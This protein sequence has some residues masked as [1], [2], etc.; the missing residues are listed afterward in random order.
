MI[1]LKYDHLEFAPELLQSV[2]DKVGTVLYLIGF[3]KEGTPV[4][5]V[6]KG[7]GVMHFRDKA[8]L[9]ETRAELKSPTPV[10][11]SVLLTPG[12][13]LIA[14]YGHDGCPDWLPPECLSHG[15]TKPDVAPVSQT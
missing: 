15:I 13:D 14:S 9:K 4:L 7:L 12:L 10:I 8:A 11:I 2:E 3:G 5:F 6:R 1:E